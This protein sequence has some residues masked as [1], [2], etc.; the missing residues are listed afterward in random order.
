MFCTTRTSKTNQFKGEK[1]KI[2]V[3]VNL[4]DN[5]YCRF[6]EDIYNKVKKQEKTGDGSLSF[7]YLCFVRYYRC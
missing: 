3:T 1:M 5:G 2:G 7:L 6:G 4:F